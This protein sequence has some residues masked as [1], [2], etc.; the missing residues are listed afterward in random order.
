[1]AEENILVEPVKCEPY[2][3]ESVVKG[4]YYE[5]KIENVYDISKFWIVVKFQELIIFMKYLK[6]F[7]SIITNRKVIPRNEFKTGLLC[8]VNRN[9]MYY[10]S[11][12]LPVLLPDENRIRVFNIDF[13]LIINVCIDEV[14]CI[15]KK[16]CSVPR[17]AIRAS[18]AN[19]SPADPSRT[20]SLSDL[21]S[22]YELMEGKRL[23][24]KV[25]EIDTKRN[26]LFVD[27]H[28]VYA[29]IFESIST[30]L[31][32]LGIAIYNQ[33]YPASYT[34]EAENKTKYK[35][36][37]KYLHLFPSFE[38]LES[39]RVPCSL[40]EYNLLKNSVPLDL[41]YK[42]YYQ[43]QDVNLDINIVNGIN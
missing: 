28:V 8:I 34:N 7:Y 35:S 13:G 26:I 39:G 17:F 3:P 41:L 29:D 30:I 22:F 25:H 32:Q 9:N 20:W 27:I 1:M 33:N 31:I 36:K 21:R 40:W 38:A 43:Y 11:I 42:D 12:M 23:L 37:V 19:I 4:Q 24:A 18:L 15:V 5:V 16:H 2:L 6:E 14:F 10:R